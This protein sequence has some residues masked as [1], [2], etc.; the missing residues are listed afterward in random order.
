MCADPLNDNFS[1]YVPE[2]IFSGDLQHDKTLSKIILIQLEKFQVSSLVSSIPLINKTVNSY[3]EEITTVLCILIPL[4]VW[5][6]VEDIMIFLGWAIFM[7]LKHWFAWMYFG[8]M[9]VK[10][11]RLKK[12]RK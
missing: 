4:D 7:S 10:F 11:K 1:C 9:I 8:S 2:Q 3:K 6:I 5:L 12:Q